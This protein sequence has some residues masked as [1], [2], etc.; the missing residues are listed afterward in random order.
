MY[1]SD[2][3]SEDSEEAAFDFASVES[4]SSG[5]FSYFDIVSCLHSDCKATGFDTTSLT[6]GLDL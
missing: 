5:I 6:V 1:L 4:S 2:T 3:G